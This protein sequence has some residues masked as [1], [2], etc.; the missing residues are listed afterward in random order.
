MEEKQVL[1]RVRRTIQGLGSFP[2]NVWNTFYRCHAT[3]NNATQK[4]ARSTNSSASV[5]PG[6][7]GNHW[8][9]SGTQECRMLVGTG[10][11]SPCCTFAAQMDWD[12]LW[13]KGMRP[14]CLTC[15]QMFWG[16]LCCFVVQHVSGQF[17]S[18]CKWYEHVL[19]QAIDRILYKAIAKYRALKVLMSASL[20]GLRLLP[21]PLLPKKITGSNTLMLLITISLTKIYNRM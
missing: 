15:L 19:F 21:C 13:G 10:G 20:T 3:R 7:P 5:V 17:T 14:Y 11:S 4:R 16:K 6:S 12:Q 2:E 9:R 18:D 1:I 8:R